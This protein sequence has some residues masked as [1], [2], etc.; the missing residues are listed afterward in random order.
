MDRQ[1]KRL[2]KEKGTV[3]QY[4]QKKRLRKEKG[5]VNQCRQ[6]KRLRQEK[7]TVVRSPA[8]LGGCESVSTEEGLRQ[9]KGTVGPSPVV[10]QSPFA[11]LIDS[12]I[13]L[14]PANHINNNNNNNNNN[15]KSKTE[16]TASVPENKS[17]HTRG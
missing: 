12:L 13:A 3:N 1:K 7:G 8:P 15:N 17:K 6:K 5:T 2:R 16:I 9:E 10:G 11:G 14:S 4:R